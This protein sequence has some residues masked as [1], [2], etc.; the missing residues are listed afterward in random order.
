VHYIH[1]SFSLHL[2][3]RVYGAKEPRLEFGMTR[4]LVLTNSTRGEARAQFAL[5][6][7]RCSGRLE[8][9]GGG[10]VRP[11]GAKLKLAVD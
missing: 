7:I 8:G 11:T 6:Q 5:V 1:V 2:A 3:A 4:I 9:R 10:V